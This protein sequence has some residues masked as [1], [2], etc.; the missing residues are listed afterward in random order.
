[1]KKRNT[2]RLSAGCWFGQPIAVGTE[3]PERV[4]CGQK[5]ALHVGGGQRGT[6]WGVREQSGTV[7][8]HGG[9]GNEQTAQ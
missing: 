4:N 8:V 1:M 2:V 3:E 9:V 6:G 7:F 5:Q